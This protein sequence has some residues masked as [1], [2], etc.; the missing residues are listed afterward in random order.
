MDALG[1][2]GPG[3]ASFVAIPCRTIEQ[4][5]AH[6][7]ATRVVEADEEGA[8]HQLIPVLLQR[9][10]GEMQAPIGPIK[11][12]QPFLAFFPLADQLFSFVGHALDELKRS[13]E[14]EDLRIV[15]DAS[16]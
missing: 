1:G 13:L 2:S 7:R 4:H 16:S 5:L 10:S 9:L 6:L 15:C 12:L 14:V 8:G 3:G 11:F